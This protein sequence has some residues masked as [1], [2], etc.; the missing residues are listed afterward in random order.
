[1]TN[2]SDPKP[3]ERRGGHK[4]R[5]WI[6]RIWDGMSFS[7]CMRVLWR[8]RFAVCPTRI[9]MALIILVIGVLVHFP[10]WLI[11]TILLGGKIKRTEINEHPIFIV[12]HWRSGT[13]LLHEFLI[14]D[15][16]HTYPSTYAC[17]APNHFLVTKYFFPAMLSI[18][19]PPSRPQDDMALGWK[20]PQEDEF[21]LCNMG[22]P[23]PYLSLM[24]A[25]RPAMD[26]EYL[27]LQGVPPDD[28]SRWKRGLMWL[29]KC[30]TLETPKRLVLKSPPHTARIDVL[31]E[32]FPDAR[33]V[34][35]YR[36]PYVVFPSTMNLW[37]RL[38]RDQGLQKPRYEGLEEYVFA[39]F[40]RMYEAFERDRPAIPANRLA[41]V[42][43]EDLIADPISQMRRI[44]GELELGEFDAVAPALEEFV[45]G[46]S[47]YKPN[48]YEISP[49]IRAEITRR[50][51]PF[52][53]KY[54]YT[55][56]E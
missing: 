50:W 7:G 22:I 45:A 35:I 12:G 38:S 30:L 24:F 36:D 56:S 15:R 54:G 52:I 17:F 32:L 33:F 29:L 11:Q 55:Q 4:D 40:K 37:K 23:S 10:F 21:A 42:R 13:T 19:M 44:Y 46:Q 14:L 8:N 34:H 47:D 43:Y 5:F 16:R 2:K 9:V 41:E 25:N 48:R 20:R 39:T 18:L 3:K 26:Q 6:P 31:R 1:M 51:A 53:E 28:L 49:E 27:D